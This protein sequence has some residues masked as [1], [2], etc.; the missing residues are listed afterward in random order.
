MGCL[1]FYVVVFFVS[2][3]LAVPVVLTR[4]ISTRIEDSR[5]FQ[6]IGP[7]LMG[8]LMA[9]YCSLGAV[10]AIKYLAF[11]EN[12][13]SYSYYSDLLLKIAAIVGVIAGVSVQI[14]VRLRTRLEK[15]SFISGILILWI[16]ACFTTLL[17]IVPE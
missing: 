6:F 4:F 12:V 17:I 8:F 11:D 5:N 7:P 14:G 15:T 10:L 1:L 9:M 16:F 3:F 13:L 2:V